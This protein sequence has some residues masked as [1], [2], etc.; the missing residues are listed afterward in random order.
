MHSRHCAGCI[1]KAVSDPHQRDFRQLPDSYGL[2]TICALKLI[3]FRH[4]LDKPHLPVT[5]LCAA[6][7]DRLER[8][9]HA[10]EIERARLEGLVSTLEKQL[11]DQSRELEEVS[12]GRGWGV[13]AD[14]DEVSVYR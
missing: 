2:N 5:L 10:N 14:L 6:F 3:V 1:D 7:Q 8:Q 12:E 9:Q 13:R 11:T 4:C